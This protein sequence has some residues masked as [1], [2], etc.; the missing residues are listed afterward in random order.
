[1]HCTARTSRPTAR[2]LAE[3]IWLARYAPVPAPGTDAEAQVRPP[4]QDLDGEADGNEFSAARAPGRSLGVPGSSPAGSGMTGHPVR[5]P[6][7]P[8]LT[9]G[10][11]LQYALRP[12]RRRIPSHRHLTFDENAT[13]T[14]IASTGLWLPVQRPAPE[15]WFE[16]ALIVDTSPSMAL[17]R[18]AAAELHTLLSGTGAVRDVRTWHLDPGKGTIS[19]VPSGPARDPRELVD[20]SGR[21]LFLVL[22]DGGAQA[23]HEGTALETLTDWAHRCPTAVLQ[24]LPEQMWARTGLPVLGARLHASTAGLPNRRLRTTF[25]R[26]RP[27]RAP[28]IPIPVL[29]VEPTALGA[30]ARLLAGTAAGVPLAITIDRGPSA[31]QAPAAP[32]GIDELGRFRASASPEA[33]QLAVCLSAVPLTLPIMRL[34]RHAA[35]PA[36]RTSALAEVLLGGLLVRTG[37]DSYEFLPGL[38]ESLRNELRRSEEAAVRAAVSGYLADT[39]GTQGQTFAGIIDAGDEAAAV[40]GE[41]LAPVPADLAARLG[42]P[43]GTD[44][45]TADIGRPAA[46]DTQTGKPDTARARSRASRRTREWTAF[47]QRLPTTAGTSRRAPSFP[48]CGHRSLTRNASRGPLRK[49]SSPLRISGLGTVRRVSTGS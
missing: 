14:F 16:V 10:R 49:Y 5:L 17:W 19:A 23:W 21:R 26:R 43:D 44:T 39:A 11:D 35:V 46:G 12:L 13:V 15:R 32:A 36:S 37:P 48:P 38:R 9:G 24:T 22:T 47:A 25:T 6:E 3:A 7:A 30:W 8:G 41:E 4:D 45:L 31:G 33:Y 2:E 27:H 29:G 28:G 42:L 20:G 34:V 1:M 18:V 40:A